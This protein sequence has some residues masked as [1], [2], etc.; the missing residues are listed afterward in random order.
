RSQQ[1]MPSENAIANAEVSTSPVG[2][3]ANWLSPIAAASAA[4]VSNGAQPATAT[5][6]LPS[7]ASGTAPSTR[8]PGDD[9]EVCAED[10]KGSM[11]L[12]GVAST[13]P[14]WMQR[15]LADTL[16]DFCFQLK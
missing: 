9:F 15:V 7:N 4:D 14:G 6:D 8:T 3:S 2:K 5:G 16:G 13:Y 10:G 11:K 12:P 1:A